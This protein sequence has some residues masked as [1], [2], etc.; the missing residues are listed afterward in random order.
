MI[1]FYFNISGYVLVKILPINGFICA[2]I[3]TYRVMKIVTRCLT[4]LSLQ[5]FNYAEYLPYFQL[6]KM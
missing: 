6:A 5:A 2:E 1:G 4:A 3:T